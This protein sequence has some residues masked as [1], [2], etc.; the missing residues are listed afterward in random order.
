[1]SEA[2]SAPEQTAVR[3]PRDWPWLAALAVFA[4]AVRLVPL[5]V[6][7]GLGFIGRYDD[8]VY[9][10]ASDALSF[11][12]VPYKH[13][14]MLHPPG[15]M[16]VLL[17]F[18]ALGRMTTDM[19]GMEVARVAFMI[20]GAANT[21]LVAVIA[22]RWG[23][24]AMFAAGLLYACWL[25]AVYA[26]QT[27][28]LEPVGG[29]FVLLA[30]YQ[31]VNTAVPPTARAGI[32]AGIWLGL[33]ATVK[34]WYVAPWA[35]IVLWRLV[36]R[37]PRSAFRIIVAGVVSVAVVVVPFA[38]LAGNRMEEMVIRDQIFRKAD[39]LSRIG[40]LSGIV[41]VR[42]FTQGSAGLRHVFTA[43]LVAIFLVVIASAL[44]DRAAR[45]VIALLVV[46]LVVLFEAPIFL[47]HY[48]A[49]VAAPA[50]LLVGV[51]VAG[52]YSSKHLRRVGPV[53][54]GTLIAGCIAL[55]ICG[56]VF[57][58]NHAFPSGRFEALAP[59]GC[60]AADDPLAL[61]E[62]NRLSSDFRERCPVDID[63]SGAL[64]DTYNL[65]YPDGMLV[66]KRDNPGWQRYLGRY[67]TSA[68]AFIVTRGPSDGIFGPIQR[69]YD[70]YPLIAKDDD[71]R[72]ELRLGADAPVSWG[73]TTFDRRDRPGELSTRSR[74]G[75]RLPGRLPL[76]RRPRPRDLRRQGQ[77]PAQPPRFV[78]PRHRRAAPAHSNHGARG[79]S[80]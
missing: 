60:I 22:R 34:I 59:S 67:L 45:P 75:S 76:S 33:A 37:D 78:L 65:T 36:V 54:L 14:I 52:F 2:A 63:V 30:L 41:G 19:T 4:F 50:A 40:R 23:R 25:P 80:G 74:L 42:S 48:A 17:P 77:E 79:I 8:G 10:A 49:F 12:R 46:N 62:V 9:Y 27:T 5:L 69:I 43:L 53:V 16:L 47:R 73:R 38:V 13:F 35:T 51:F 44:R 32:A 57:S 21:V 71:S 18:V 70:G 1:V 26:E 56:S 64:L 11:G 7:G 20:I 6:S 68:R 58:D 3:R 61:A 55:G 72:D 39:S 15:I 31:L 24:P 66:P 28:F 29:L